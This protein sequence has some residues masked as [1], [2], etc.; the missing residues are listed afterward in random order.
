[1]SNKKSVES[2]SPSDERLLKGFDDIVVQEQEQILPSFGSSEKQ[3][4]EEEQNIIDL[5]DIKMRAEAL[6]QKIKETK[7][8]IDNRC[9]DL[10]VKVVE[11]EDSDDDLLKAMYRVFKER[12]TT[13]TYT[14]YKRAL[15][16]REQLAKEDE[17]LLR[18]S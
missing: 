14:H 9:K 18:R 7:E 10:S 17:M 11:G 8:E 3:V 5:R 16:L 13:I 12:T 4:S 1:M 15:E 6:L 2:I